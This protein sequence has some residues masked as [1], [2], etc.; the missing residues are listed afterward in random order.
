MTLVHDGA[1]LR[2]IEGA[3]R[4]YVSIDGRVFSTCRGEVVELRQKRLRAKYGYMVA[5]IRQGDRRRKR[6]VHQL[7]LEAFVGPRPDGHETR[8]LDNDATNNRLSNLEWTTKPQNGEDRRAA[9]S[10]KGERHGVAKLT[11]AAVRS[12]RARVAAGAARRSVA[13]E[14]GVSVAAIDLIVTRKRWAHV[15]DADA[16]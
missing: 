2:E 9:G 12:I 7:V 6:Y 10:H 13:S 15:G 4:Y 16:H 1:E 5:D 8:H 3:P 11:D 14:H